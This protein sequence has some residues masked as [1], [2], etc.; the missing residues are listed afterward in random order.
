MQIVV[1]NT[2]PKVVLE[3]PKDGQLFS[4][5]DPIPFKVRVTD[6][7]DGTAIDCAKVEVTFVLGHDSHGHPVTSANGCTGTLQTSADGGHDEDANIFGVLDAEYTDGGGGGQAALTSHDQNVLQPRHRQAEHFGASSG[8]TVT[9]R[10]SAHGG[11][12]VGDLARGDWISFT[13]YALGNARKVTVR[14]SSAGVGGTL[15][16]RAGSPKGVLLGK[17]TV[18][19]TGGWDTYQDVSAALSRVP[20]GT[21]TLY[22]VVKG[23]SGSRYENGP[24]YEVDDFTFTTATG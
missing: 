3:T 13:P 17:A 7:E 19:V 16:V 10:A 9:A 4:F 24:L 6:P 23:G 18:P 1:G 20:K 11:R 5:G 21:T 22:L 2:A 8:V 12:T 14:V 15:E